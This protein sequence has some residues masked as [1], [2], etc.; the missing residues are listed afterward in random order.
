[1]I[2]ELI[3]SINVENSIILLLEIA[4]VVVIFYVLS[5]M[6]RE[7]L[8]RNADKEDLYDDDDDFLAL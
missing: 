6:V 3:K 2:K 1:M 8:N 4:A 7:L 5:D